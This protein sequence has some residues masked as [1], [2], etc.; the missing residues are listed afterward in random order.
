MPYSVSNMNMPGYGSDT[1]GI[2]PDTFR[3]L[4]VLSTLGKCHKVL[5]LQDSWQ[6]S[7]GLF[8]TFP[9]NALLLP[10]GYGFDMYQMRLVRKSPQYL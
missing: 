6:L 9:R 4:R 2:Q 5:S 8:M 1:A 7:E 3:I 10:T